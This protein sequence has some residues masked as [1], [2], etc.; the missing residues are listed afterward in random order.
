MLDFLYDPSADSDIRQLNT[1]ANDVI[2]ADNA[3]ILDA[4][5]SQPEFIGKI[6]SVLVP[7]NNDEMRK[8][9]TDELASL[10]AITRRIPLICAENFCRL[11]FT[12]IKQQ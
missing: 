11:V 2:M 3:I 6:F 10:P 4:I 1:A 7:Y 9:N 12:L 5:A 8:Y